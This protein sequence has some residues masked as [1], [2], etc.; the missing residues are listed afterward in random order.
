[1]LAQLWPMFQIAVVAPR[2]LG[3]RHMCASQAEKDTKNIFL[4]NLFDRHG[5]VRRIQCQKS[6]ISQLD[7]DSCY[8]KDTLDNQHLVTLLC[9]C[10]KLLN[11]GYGLMIFKRDWGDED[12]QAGLEEWSV[13]CQSALFSLT[14][15]FTIIAQMFRISP[16]HVIGDRRNSAASLGKEGRHGTESY[17]HPSFNLFCVACQLCEIVYVL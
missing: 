2:Q 7:E 13:G 15:V 3:R 6:Q 17:S 8:R 9:S 10:T 5:M 12:I 4:G 16:F 14:R 1:M 11:V